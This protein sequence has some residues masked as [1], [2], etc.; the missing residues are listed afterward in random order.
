MSDAYIDIET[1]KAE[2]ALDPPPTVIDVR[3]R[4]EYAAGHI[5]GALHIPGDQLPILLA[6]LPRDRP[7]VTY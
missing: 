1:L 2:L 5:P 6:E 3:S 7:V 4:D